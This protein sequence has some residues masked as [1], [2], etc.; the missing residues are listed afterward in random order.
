MVT[1]QYRQ[2]Y[3]PPLVRQCGLP[4]ARC[5]YFVGPSRSTDLVSVSHNRYSV[6]ED[7]V[8]PL[9]DG[10]RL[11]A[12]IWLPEEV[13]QVPVPPVLEFLPYRRR[14]GTAARDES[15]YPAFA[16]EVVGWIAGQPVCT[17]S[18]GMTG[19]SW[20]GLN[21]LQVAALHPPP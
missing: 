15:T 20:G 6:L 21:S 19:M 10:V 3:L 12:R 16:D 18:V 5:V 9:Q 1:K 2:I 14:D 4:R 13:Q 11:Y 7:V 17:G 8:I